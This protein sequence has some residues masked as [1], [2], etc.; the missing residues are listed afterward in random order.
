M[1]ELLSGVL[2]IFWHGFLCQKLLV[3]WYLC[4]LQ[5]NFMVLYEKIKI[6]VLV[7]RILYWF[8]KKIVIGR[9]FLCQKLIVLWYLS[10]LYLQYNFM[11][12]YEKL[13]CVYLCEGSF[14]DLYEKKLLYLWGILCRIFNICSLKMEL[15]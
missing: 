13:K 11:D 12:L 8:K 6:C 5:Y 4:Y 2:Q 15:L 1:S 7:W 9:N 14:I 10:Y 3:L